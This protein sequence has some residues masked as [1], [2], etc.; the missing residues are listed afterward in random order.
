MSD[1]LSRSADVRTIHHGW[2]DVGLYP[3]SRSD[4]RSD[5]DPVRHQ[6]GPDV[7]DLMENPRKEHC[8]PQKMKPYWWIP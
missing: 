7:A 5:I 4:V 8:R 3:R 1:R 6:R 2:A